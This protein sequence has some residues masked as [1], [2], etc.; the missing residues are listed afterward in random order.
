MNTNNMYYFAWKI[1]LKGFYVAIRMERWV[2]SI[3]F[4]LIL[5]QMFLGK[6]SLF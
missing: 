5:P 4:H 3:E 2:R 6:F 1:N